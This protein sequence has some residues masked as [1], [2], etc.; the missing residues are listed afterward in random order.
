MLAALGNLSAIQVCVRFSAL[1]VP[2]QTRLLS[3]IVLTQWLFAHGAAVVGQIVGR[4]S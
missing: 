1:E 3:G 2:D 4:D